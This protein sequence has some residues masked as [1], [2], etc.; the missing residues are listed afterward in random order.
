MYINSFFLQN[1]LFD[2]HIFQYLCNKTTILN[3][4]FSFIYLMFLVAL[5]NYQLLILLH[6]SSKYLEQ[7]YY[8]QTQFPGDFL[9]AHS[10]GGSIS[11]INLPQYSCTAIEKTWFRRVAI[12]IKIVDII[13]CFFPPFL[14]DITYFYQCQWSVDSWLLEPIVSLGTQ[15][16]RWNALRGGLFKRCQ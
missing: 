16:Y 2:T 5:Q 11:S 3:T 4:Y 9:L 8:Q 13:W 10:T 12:K 14:A 15:A 6:N 7:I 1:I